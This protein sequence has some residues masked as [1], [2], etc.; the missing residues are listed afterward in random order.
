MT[1]ELLK[2]SEFAARA[3]ASRSTVLRDVESGAID[4]VYVCRVGSDLR[5]SSAFFTDKSLN[6][7][8]P[9]AVLSSAQLSDLG[10]IVADKLADRMA[11]GF[12]AAVT[13]RRS[14]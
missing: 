11:M 13:E 4:P 1:I 9:V 7:H 8:P 12:A 14:A 3:H 5:I 2:V 6:A 10:S